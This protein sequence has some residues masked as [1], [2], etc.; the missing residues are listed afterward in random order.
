MRQG[1]LSTNA[2]NGRWMRRVL[3]PFWML[4]PMWIGSHWTRGRFTTS[5]LGN[6]K[7]SLMMSLHRKPPW[8]GI[9]L[10]LLVWLSASCSGRPGGRKWA[11]VSQTEAEHVATTNDHQLVAA[12]PQN[13]S[14][15]GTTKAEGKTSVGWICPA[16][17]QFARLFSQKVTHLS[18]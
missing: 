9:L 3:A 5:C 14:C 10:H 18:G 15:E 17:E 6:T 2:K 13:S 1:S 8:I 7:A 12:C 11:L 16:M 4:E